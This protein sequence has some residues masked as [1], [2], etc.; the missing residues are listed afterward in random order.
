MF[1]AAMGRVLDEARDAKAIFKGTGPKFE[2]EAYFARTRFSK[3]AFT[4]LRG[5]CVSQGSQMTERFLELEARSIILLR[6]RGQYQ[7][8]R[9]GFDGRS[10]RPPGSTWCYRGQGKT[11]REEAIAGMERAKVVIAETEP[12]AT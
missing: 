2:E 8:R 12:K 1:D 6:K 10:Q 9:S 7:W 11:L 3:N 4:E 5:A